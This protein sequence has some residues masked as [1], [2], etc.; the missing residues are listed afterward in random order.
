MSRFY[1]HVRDGDV[2]VRDNMGADLEDAEAVRFQARCVARDLLAQ[3]ICADMKI[4]GREIIVVDEAG[5]D[6][7]HLPVR[8]VLKL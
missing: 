1:F 6:V 3:A 7:L 2:V 5:A 4:N 8:D